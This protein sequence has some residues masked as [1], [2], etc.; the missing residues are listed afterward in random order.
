MNWNF[1]QM[2]KTM[3]RSALEQEQMG[4]IRPE[5]SIVIPLFNEADNI[6]ALYRA[7]EAAMDQCGRAWEVIFVDDGSQDATYQV[8]EQLQTHDPR[9]CVVRLRRNFG[10]TAA[11]AAGFDHACGK[12]I[13]ALDG[14]LQNDPKDIGRLLEKIDE[15]YDVVSG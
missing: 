12:T 1:F 11:M 3:A 7:L 10:Q 4:R 5:V 8:L 9:V 15:G 13:V 2:E 14:D 6:P